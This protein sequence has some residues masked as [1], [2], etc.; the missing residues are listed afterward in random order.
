MRLFVLTLL[1]VPWNASY[2]QEHTWRFTVEGG[3]LFQTV[4]DV[5]IP[6]DTGTRFSLVDAVGKGPFPYA[7]LELKYAITPKHRLRL[8]VA[9]LVIEKSGQLDKDVFYDGENFAANTDTTYRYQF[10]SYRLSYAYRFYQTPAWKWDVGITGKIRDA[11]IALKQGNTKS[12]YPNVGFVPLLYLAAER[13]INDNWQ[14]QM[15]LD[16]LGSPYGR[17]IDFGVFAHYAMNKRWQFGAGYRTLEGGADVSRVYNF[18]WLHYLG[19]R[20]QVSI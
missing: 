13:T 9:P 3:A 6:P 10:N 8:L 5:Q 14:I 4:S 16:A 19:L 11:E 2:A 20:L 7:R 15:D 12:S 1:L 18:A 17:A